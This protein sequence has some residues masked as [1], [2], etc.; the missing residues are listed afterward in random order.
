MSKLKKGDYVQFFD[1]N[2]KPCLP[3]QNGI[4]LITQ[5]YDPDFMEKMAGFDCEIRHIELNLILITQF[6]KLRKL[7]TSTV[8]VLYE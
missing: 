4:F 5:V 7:E 2:E 8:K 1:P 6:S 3:G